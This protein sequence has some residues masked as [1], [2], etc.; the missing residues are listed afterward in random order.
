MDNSPEISVDKNKPVEKT[1]ILIKVYNRAQAR[2]CDALGILY[3]RVEKTPFV[4]EMK[5]EYNQYR[6]DLAIGNGSQTGQLKKKHI[7]RER[8]R[9][10]IGSGEKT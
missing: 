9:T 6:R 7:N 2:R 5:Q 3:E 10:T 1:K 4:D 8:I